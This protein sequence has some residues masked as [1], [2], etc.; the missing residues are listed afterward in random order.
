MEWLITYSTSHVL[1]NADNCVPIVPCSDSQGCAIDL[2]KWH[3]QMRC[4]DYFHEYFQW[5]PVQ[6]NG[7]V[8]MIS[9]H[10]LNNTDGNQNR[11]MPQASGQCMKQFWPGCMSLYG[12]N[13]LQLI[14][15]PRF[16]SHIRYWIITWYFKA[17]N[18]GIKI[19]E[20]CLHRPDSTKPLPEPI[21]TSH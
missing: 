6:V 13:R 10:C 4:S 16:M 1:S 14:N 3:F 19:L 11:Y 5:C 7:I 21:L 9:H 18:S 12:V 20:M 2:K 15:W 8:L 17:Y